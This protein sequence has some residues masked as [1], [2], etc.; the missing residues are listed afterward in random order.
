[1]IF[2]SSKSFLVY[3]TLLTFGKSWTSRLRNI[4][5]GVLYFVWFTVIVEITCKF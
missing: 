4:S 1:M 5:T 2:P 3:I